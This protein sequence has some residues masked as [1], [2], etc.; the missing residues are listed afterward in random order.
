VVQWLIVHTSRSSK[1]CLVM[2]TSGSTAVAII[3]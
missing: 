1:K 3:S 2:T